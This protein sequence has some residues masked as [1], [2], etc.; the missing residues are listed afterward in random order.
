MSNPQWALVGALPFPI[1]VPYTHQGPLWVKPGTGRFPI[2]GGP[3]RLVGV[4]AAVDTAPTGGPVVLDVT[5]NGASVYPTPDAR[6][7]IPADATV[8]VASGHTPTIV[9]EGDTV[10]VDIVAVG[11]G[12][13]GGGLVVNVLLHRTQQ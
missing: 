2:V 10:R 6:P 12:Q 7:T 1:S 5:V 13:P 11:T 4:A 3:Y 8:T 9:S